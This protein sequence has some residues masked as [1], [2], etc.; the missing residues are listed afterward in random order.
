MQQ[1]M[2]VNSFIKNFLTFFD[3]LHFVNISPRVRGLV[4]R[5]EKLYNYIMDIWNYLKFTDRPIVLYGMG[6]GADKIIAALDR[7]KIYPKG[8]FASDGFV[9]K[10]VFHGFPVTGYAEAKRQ[11]PDMIALLCF[12]TG[13]KDVISNIRRIAGETELLA[14]DVPV[15][16]STLFNSEYAL[17][18]EYALRKVYSV[19]ADDASKR[20]FENIVRYKLSGNID[21]LF[22]CETSPDEPYETFFK[23]GSREL[24][25]DLG[26]YRG[27][28]VHDFTHRTEAYK[29]I[30]AVEPDIKT[31][32][33]LENGTAE[34]HDI[35]R[36]NAFAGERCGT[37]NFL[38]DSS[39][40]SKKGD[41]K[42]VPSVTVDSLLGGG[43]AT[44][45][46]M[47]IEGGE[48]PAI[49]GAE[50]TISKFKPKMKIAAYHRTEDILEIPLKVLSLCSDY[51]VYMRH[52][53][54]L[55]AWDTD[56]YFV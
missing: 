12:G 27:D 11:F 9:R 50:H 24:Y 43:E 7:Y 1:I 47:D 15:C 8:V 37:V 39:R 45:I 3:L 49:S 53:P 48:I 38:M 33:K 22:G 26:A 10:K 44:F 5:R 35:S 46:K 56:Y 25:M 40:G 14:P 32:A 34:F 30:Y 28:T 2:K 31:F 19:L 13:L 6:D 54:C 51:K 36:I 23:L 17:E 55:P 16:G 18:N 21:L 41:G 29:H 52:N 4:K 20:C 42:A